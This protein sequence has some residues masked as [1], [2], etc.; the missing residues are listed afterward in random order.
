VAHRPSAP[1]I[2]P[3]ITSQFPMAVSKP[4]EAIHIGHNERE[5]FVLS[6]ILC[7]PGSVLRHFRRDIMATYTRVT[8]NVESFNLGNFS[9]SG[10][11][12]CVMRPIRVLSAFGSSPAGYRQSTTV[13]GSH[14]ST[15]GQN[16]SVSQSTSLKNNHEAALL[17]WHKNCPKCSDPQSPTS[18]DIKQIYLFRSYCSQSHSVVFNTWSAVRKQQQTRIP[19]TINE[20]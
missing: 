3:K 11:Q 16:S 8:T 12:N 15:K 1:L 7:G 14:V 2:L 17:R 4:L 13:S 9:L 19:K 6:G 10:K 5:H 18:G 20:G